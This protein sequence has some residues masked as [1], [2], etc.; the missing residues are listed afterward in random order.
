MQHALLVCYHAVPSTLNVICPKFLDTTNV[1]YL[2]NFFHGPPL[3]V[4]MVNAFCCLMST[5]GNETNA[6]LPSVVMQESVRRYGSACRQ[7]AHKGG[8]F[9]KENKEQL[10]H[11]MPCE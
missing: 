2:W 9:D 10:S 6:L 1:I 7:F 11:H 4:V 8:F 5:F 3:Y